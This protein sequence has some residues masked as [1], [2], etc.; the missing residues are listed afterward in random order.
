LTIVCSPQPVGK[1]N[2]L[3]TPDITADAMLSIM[4]PITDERINVFNYNIVYLNI[5][6]HFDCITAQTNIEIKVGRQY[7]RRLFCVLYT[8]R[9][10]YI[11]IHVLRSNVIYRCV[12]NTCL[13]KD[14]DA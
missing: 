2:I 11:R 8:I 7:L 3:S 14:L 10:L 5:I 4:L 1:W 13:L 6:G 12:V 9:Q